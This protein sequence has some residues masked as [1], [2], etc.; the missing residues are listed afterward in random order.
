MRLELDNVGKIKYANIK[1][2]GITVIA[3][4]NNT[5]KSTIGKMLYCI[6]N[7]FYKIDNQVREE[8]AKSISRQISNYYFESSNRI[9]RRFSPMKLSYEIVELKEEYL[10]GQKSLYE[11][12]KEYY[13][14][15]DSSFQKYIENVD[16][17]EKMCKRVHHLL[18]IKDDEIRK[19]ILKKNLE[20]EFSMNVSHLN[21]IQDESK[22]KLQIKDSCIEFQVTDNENVKIGNYISLIKEIIY[23]DDPFVLDNL[24]TNMKYSRY[25]YQNHSM[26]LLGKLMH[27]S[28][29]DEF[30]TV[31]ELVVQ[32]KLDKIFVAMKDVCDGDL[33]SINEGDKYVYKT[34]KLKDS[35]DIVNL[36]TGIKSFI[37]IR[38]LLKNGSIDDNGVIILDEPE[39]HLHPEW[40][41]K[42]AEV[43]VLIQKEFGMN[44]LLNTHSPYFLNAIEV[45]SKRYGIDSSCNY[46]MTE[47]NN[48]GIEVLD[49]TNNTEPIYAKLA[50]PLQDLEN[51]EYRDEYSV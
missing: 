47:E 42:F 28:D 23:V 20:M 24:N 34:N 36:S 40:Q 38:E 12:I 7:S 10:S 19:T 16:A 51:M 15:I 35:L 33:M 44:V 3:G 46:Y 11:T 50:R 18:S 14:S 27:S 39:I 41:L 22:V 4:E 17:F 45:Y 43:I 32:D 1:L 37:I 29:N 13:I 26:K 8:R 49:V 9:S 2:D 5:G 30:G 48:S 21:H 25:V 31:D 6:Y